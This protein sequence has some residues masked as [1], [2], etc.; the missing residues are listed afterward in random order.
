MTVNQAR[1]LAIAL[2]ET[3]PTDPVRKAHWIHA[4]RVLRDIVEREIPAIDPVI[5]ENLCYGPD[6]GPD[7][8]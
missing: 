3:K 7:E 1:L 4:M 2:C 8:D 5:W 6:Y